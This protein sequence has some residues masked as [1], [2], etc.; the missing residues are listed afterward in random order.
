MPLPEVTATEGKLYR[1][2]IQDQMDYLDGLAET[3]T[4][5]EDLATVATSGAYSDLSGAPAPGLSESFVPIWAEENG[6]LGA[7][8]YEWA[9]GNGADT[10]NNNGI[11]IYVPSGYEV[12]IVAMGATT[13]NAAGSPT[14]EVEVN[15]SA[16]GASDGI[17]I[18]LAGRSG[19]NDSFAPYALSS[20]DRLNFRTISAGTSTSPHTA[21]AWLRYR[22]I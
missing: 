8:T 5:P 12:H 6:V 16:L 22:L 1:R 20:A 17:Q 21:V 4:Q 10:P 2:Q 11:S 18:T 7:N 3:A 14:I 9:F 19:I 15:G 13:N